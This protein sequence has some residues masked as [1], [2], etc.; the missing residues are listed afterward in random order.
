MQC[1]DEAVPSSRKHAE[2]YSVQFQRG[3][4]DLREGQ[5]EETALGSQP[6]DSPCPVSCFC[7]GDEIFSHGKPTNVT[8]CFRRSV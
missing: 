3:R 7:V 2:R 6:Q 5:R 8:A 4:A 1:H